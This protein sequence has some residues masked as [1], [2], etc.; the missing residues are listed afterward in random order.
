VPEYTATISARFSGCTSTGTVALFSLSAPALSLA[1]PLL[2][3]VAS[4]PARAT[5]ASQRTELRRGSADRR[6]WF[7]MD[8]EPLWIGSYW[9]QWYGTLVL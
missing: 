5:S 8:I 3:P 1:L 9:A 2:Q 6:F 4:A 7:V